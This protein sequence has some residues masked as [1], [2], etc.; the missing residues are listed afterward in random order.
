MNDSVIVFKND[1]MIKL[2]DL[3]VIKLHNGNH[4]M[5]TFVSAFLIAGIGYAS[6]NVI[7]N[8]L[9]ESV[10]R[11]DPKAMIVSASFLTAAIILKQISIKRIHMRRNVSLKVLDLNFQ[12]LN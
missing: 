3:K 10:F 9:I 2:S 7:N 4:L 5:G 8:L 11:L 1:S 12:K 6:L